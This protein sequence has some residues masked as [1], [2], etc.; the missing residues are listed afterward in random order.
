MQK[1][2]CLNLS[3]VDP[4]GTRVDYEKEPHNPPTVRRIMD[5]GLKLLHSDIHCPI[6]AEVLLPMSCSWP[7]TLSGKNSKATLFQMV[8]LGSR[9]LDSLGKAF[10]D[11]IGV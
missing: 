9:T 3:E 7:I 11:C 1:R 10:L 5:Q 2:S 4:H 6:S 8:H